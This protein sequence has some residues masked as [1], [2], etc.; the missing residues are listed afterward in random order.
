MDCLECNFTIP[1][2]PYDAIEYQRNV[3]RSIIKYFKHYQS[4]VII[5]C[6]GIMYFIFFCLFIVCRVDF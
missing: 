3:S 5:V 4:L 6:V 2:L 1:F